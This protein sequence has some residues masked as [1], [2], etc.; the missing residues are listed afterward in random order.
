MLMQEEELVWE[1]KF[2]TNKG[3][4]TGMTMGVTTGM[5]MGMMR[6]MMVNNC[7]KVEMLTFVKVCHLKS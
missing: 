7:F 2:E 4:M 3:M 6:E 5:T 1:S